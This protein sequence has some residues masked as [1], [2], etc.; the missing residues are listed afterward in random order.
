MVI[1]SIAV[2]AHCFRLNN[3]YIFIKAYYNFYYLPGKIYIMKKD[4][5]IQKD[6]MEQ[7]KW[8]PILNSYS[9][10]IGVAVNDGI[11]TLSGILNT[12]S[13]KMAAE[14]AVKKISGVRA[15]AMDI[16]VGGSPAEKK[17]DAEIAKAVLNALKW[18]SAVPE[19]SLQIKVEDGNVTLDGQVE[20]E[21]Q[22]NSV[23]NAV[24]NIAGVRNVLNNLTI[25]PKVTPTD[26][27]Q[28]IT[29]AFHRSATIDASRINVE[30][31]GNKAIVSGKVRSFAE[32]EDA[33]E[34]AWSA[35]GISLVESHL[36]LETIEVLTV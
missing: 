23:K 28:K 26:V 15:I 7:L 25:V 32:K 5:E 24:G 12:Y 35:P 13:E 31:I 34:A 11:V 19:E 14:R 22:R 10:E 18:H 9:S 6:V 20:W 16:Q 21:Y 36:E 3:G 30:V 17:T 1:T 4:S 29:A 33:E 8:E 27:K 2:H